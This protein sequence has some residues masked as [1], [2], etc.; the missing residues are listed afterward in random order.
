V[1]LCLKKIGHPCFKGIQRE[2]ERERERG[3]GGGSV[4]RK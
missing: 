4:L 2:R 3:V 1:A